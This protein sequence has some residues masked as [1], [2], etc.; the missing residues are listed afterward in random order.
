MHEAKKRRLRNLLKT[1]S[2]GCQVKKMATPPRPRSLINLTVDGGRGS[3]RHSPKIH[4]TPQQAVGVGLLFVQAKL[5]GLVG[6]S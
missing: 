6:K 2:I 5:L 1:G 4:P 3:T